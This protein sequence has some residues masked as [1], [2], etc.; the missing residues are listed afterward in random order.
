MR[1]SVA[2][3]QEI[4][5]KRIY[6]GMAVILLA[7]GITLQ[8]IMVAVTKCALYSGWCLKEWCTEQDNIIMNE[9]VLADLA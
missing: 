9:K 1:L 4:I 5:A 8:T 2:N 6:A 3:L 7:R